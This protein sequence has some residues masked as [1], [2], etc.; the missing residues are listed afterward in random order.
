MIPRLP[1]LLLAL[2]GGASIY[3]IKHVMDKL[4]QKSLGPP[5][6][7]EH[8]EKM[9]RFRRNVKTIGMAT[10][11][12]SVVFAGYYVYTSRQHRET[13]AAMYNR[14]NDDELFYQDQYKERERRYAEE[15]ALSKEKEKAKERQA[16]E[17]LLKEK[18]AMEQLLSGHLSNNK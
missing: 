2:L 17:H 4:E 5:G 14:N 1:P 10:A 7:S 8:Y 11:F 6:S 12:T 18:Q 15:R 13:P 9:Y 3:G 16:K